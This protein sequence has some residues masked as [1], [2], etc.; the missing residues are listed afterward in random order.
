[1]LFSSGLPEARRGTNRLSV[2]HTYAVKYQVIDIPIKSRNYEIIPSINVKRLLI[3]A[4][5][6][7][8]SFRDVPLKSGETN[9]VNY[10]TFIGEKQ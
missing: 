2:T 8:N 1:M 6:R 4:F 9:I 3:Y 7:D 10:M 5:L